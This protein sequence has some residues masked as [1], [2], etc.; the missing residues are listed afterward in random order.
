[1]KTYKTI[2]GEIRIEKVIDKSKF[3]GYAKPI[4]N[5]EEG[6]E[7]VREIKKKHKDASHNV[8]AII[9]GDSFQFQWASDDGEPQGTSGAP[10]LQMLQQEG[11]TD[12]VVVVTRYFGGIKLGTGGLVRAYTSTAK[13]AIK[14]ARIIEYKPML[15]IKLKYPYSLHGKIEGVLR[16]VDASVENSVFLEDVAIELMMTFEEE[17]NL[18]K[19]IE[20]LSGINIINKESVYRGIELI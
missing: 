13:L 1:M 14:E 3:I 9:L 17:S 19:Q 8:P 7:F 18:L 11:V 10:I 5:R 20:P 4:K 2:K 16:R 12:V 15:L 6:E